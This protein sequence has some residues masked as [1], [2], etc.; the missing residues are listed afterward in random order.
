MNPFALFAPAPHAPPLPADRVDATYRRERRLVFAGIFAG[1]AGYYLLRKNIALANPEL[2]KAGLGF[3]KSDLGLVMG[4]LS[5]T[6]GLSKFLMATVSDR[7]HP[8]WFLA[9]GLLLTLAVNL[10]FGLWP[11]VTTHFAL[12]FALMAVNGWVQ[13]MGW[14]PCGRVMV[15]WFSLRERGTWMAAWNVAHNVGAM[16]VGPLAVLGA[17]WMAPGRAAFVMPSIVAAAI[18]LFVLVSVRDTPQSRGLPPVEAWRDDPPDPAADVADR[19]R[20]LTTREI[21]FDH[22]LRSRALWIIAFAN[23]FVY[24]VRYGVLDWAPTYL[25]EVKG[26]CFDKSGYAFALYELAGIPGTLLCG[27]LSDRLFGG[28][29]GP[30]GVLFMAGVAAA[31][32]VYWF[33]PPGR[34]WVD[35]AA[36]FAIGFLIYGPVMLIGVQALDLVPKKAAGTA[37]GFTGLFGYLGGALAANAAMGFFVERFGWDGGFALLTGSC[38]VAIA[39]LAWSSREGGAPRTAPASEGE[40]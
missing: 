39:L 21:L 32:L 31:T 24:F 11:A 18:L 22:V 26:F 29:R 14:P 38:F 15:H 17:V 8:K 33:N 2:V 25:Q 27:Y 30:A 13:G 12:A 20:E 10:L 7:C 36:L 40:A 16:L 9:A 28:R 19:E 4:A 1:Y 35:F 6:Y 3:A 5:L 23:V 37:A 34:P